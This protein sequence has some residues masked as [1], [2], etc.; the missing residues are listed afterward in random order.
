MLILILFV[1]LITTIIRT[2]QYAAFIAEFRVDKTTTTT[3]YIACF[4]FSKKDPLLYSIYVILNDVIIG[5]HVL[6]IETLYQQVSGILYQKLVSHCENRRG[7][8]VVSCHC[9]VWQEAI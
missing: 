9:Q 8:R 5:N 3:P 1:F 2:C 7:K 4:L 6:L